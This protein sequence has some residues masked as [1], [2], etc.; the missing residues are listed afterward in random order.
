VQRAYYEQESL[1]RRQAFTATGPSGEEKEFFE[2]IEKENDELRKLLSASTEERQREWERAEQLDDELRHEQYVVAELR[3]SLIVAQQTAGGGVDGTLR[4]LVASV[5]GA[6]PNVSTALSLC[7]ALFP[8]RLLI[9]DSARKS[10][11]DHE[12]FRYGD[13][14]FGLLY[15]LAGSYFDVLSEGGSDGEARKVFGQFEF[16]AKEANLSKVGKAARTFPVHGLGD[17]LMEP[18]LKI[19]RGDNRAESFRCHFEWLAGR[20]LIAIGH[21]GEHLPM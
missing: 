13:Q 20:K 4:Q 9:L 21:C 2:L 1:K 7:G 5:V 15:R 19:Q 17:V 14:V 18:H 11:A 6:K 3:R 8:D 10:A 16:A 12:Q